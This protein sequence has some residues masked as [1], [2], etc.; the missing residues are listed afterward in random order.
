[1]TAATIVGLDIKHEQFDIH[2]LSDEGA[3][4]ATTG[5][6]A[7]ERLVNC[8]RRRCPDLVVIESRAEQEDFLAAKLTAEGLPVIVVNPTRVREYARTLGRLAK[9]RT[10]NAYILTRLA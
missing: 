7:V 5:S 9:G 1:M 3:V 6:G 4:P 10:T 8:I 2:E